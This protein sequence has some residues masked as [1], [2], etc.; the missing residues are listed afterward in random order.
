[1]DKPFQRK[2]ATSN[3]AVG[4]EF[5]TK[6]KKYFTRQ[7]YNLEDEHQIPISITGNRKKKH[8]FDLVDTGK[9]I[10]IECKSSKWTEGNKKPSA[11]MSQ[12][13][14]AMYYFYMAPKTYTKILCVSR[15]YSAKY[16]ETL[17]EYYIRTYS[18]LIPKDVQIWE[19]NES[20]HK[21]APVTFT[22][23]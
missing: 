14:E 11:K 17:A 3:S 5:Q 22:E 7:G 4:R 19:Y 13:N 21:A 15:E 20:T 16:K 10:L 9:K 12:W 1:M 18:Y 8:S 2:G 23:K 6:V